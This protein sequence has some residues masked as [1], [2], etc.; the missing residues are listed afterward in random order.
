MSAISSRSKLGGSGGGSCCSPGSRCVVGQQRS[1]GMLAE[2]L[3]AT[4]RLL[5]QDVD[6]DVG[7]GWPRSKSSA[8]NAPGL[9]REMV[10]HS[11]IATPETATV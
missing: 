11:L 5:G 6:G 7:R 8:G 10:R 9:C 3:A 2:H 1:A 4:D